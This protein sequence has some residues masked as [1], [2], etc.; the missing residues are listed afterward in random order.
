[1][2][3]KQDAEDDL[4]WLEWGILQIS[5]AQKSLLASERD[6]LYAEAEQKLIRSGQL[7][8]QQAFYHLACYYSLKRR[9]DEAMQF[10]RKAHESDTLPSLEEMQ[11]DEW[12]E[13]MQTFDE[14][15]TFVQ[16]LENKQNISDE[17]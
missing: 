14:Y 17:R 4:T 8:N 9:Y 13:P 11:E 6:Q 2:A 15:N 16:E 3:I 7:G 12:L 1:M 5:F 10:L